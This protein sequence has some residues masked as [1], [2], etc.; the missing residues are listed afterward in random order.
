M[1]PATPIIKFALPAGS[2]N[3]PGRGN[4]SQMISDAGYNIDGYEPGKE[5]MR[6][7]FVNDKEIEAFVDR[8]QNMPVSLSEGVYDLAI[9]GS[10]WAREWELAGIKIGQMTDLD[11]GRA[12]IVLAVKSESPVGNI[13]Q[14]VESSRSTLV[15]LSTEYLL[16][17]ANSVTGTDAWRAAYGTTAKPLFDTRIMQR[18]AIIERMAAGL[19]ISESFGKTEV[20]AI[21]G[22]GI[23]A[24]VE[25]TQ[26][27]RSLTEAILKPVGTI[28]NSTACLYAS[29]SALG[30]PAKLEKIGQVAT[31][32]MGVVKGRNS[33]YV[34]FNVPEERLQCI[35][36]YLILNQ[37]TAKMPT[38]SVFGGNAVVSTV[39][40]KGEY[41]KAILGLLGIGADDIVNIRTGQIVA[42]RQYARAGK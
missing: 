24:I 9:L 36:N 27:G 13:E 15:R 21:N 7:M 8:P 14:L 29:L 30:E 28:F 16:I 18:R 32:L 37:Y 1:K 17:A 10:D 2:L 12:T 26:T 5:S 31:L 39:L 6:P 22:S 20:G 19:V 33:E 42:R 34:S 25:N 38:V 40:P 11:Y 3:N 35:V 23:D 41:P 4:T